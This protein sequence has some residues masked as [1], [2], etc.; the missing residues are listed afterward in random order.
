MKKSWKD[1]ESERLRNNYNYGLI[2]FMSSVLLILSFLISTGVVVGAAKGEGNKQVI[3]LV[4]DGLT[5]EEWEYARK[6]VPAIDKFVKKSSL[7]LMNTGTAGRLSSENACVTIGA[8]ARALGTGMAGLALSKD[9]IIDQYTAGVIYRRYTGKYPQGQVVHLG[10]NSLVEVNDSHHYRVEPGALGT[11][12][13]G[14]GMKTALLG[15]GDG[16][17]FNRLASTLIMDNHGMIDYG[18]VGQEI[19]KEGEDYPF[20]VSID[21]DKMWEGFLELVDKSQVIVI[22]WGDM[23]RLREKVPLLSPEKIRVN[24]DLQIENLGLFLERIM[25]LLGEERALLLFTPHPQGII[26]PSGDQISFLAMNKGPETPPVFLSSGTTQRPGLIASIDIA[27]SILDLLGLSY[28]SYL[29]GS[30]LFKIESG[31]ENNLSSLLDLKGQIN[32]IHQQRPAMIK[33]YIFSQIALVLLAV[34]ALFL[35]I[36][37]YRCIRL[38]MVFLMLA[39]LSFLIYGA[40]K[41]GNLF[42]AFLAVILLTILLTAVTSYGATNTD[43][44]L[45]VG[46]MVSLALIGDVL[47]GANLMKNSI[48]GYDPISGARFYGIGN[49]YMGVL[50]GASVLFSASLYQKKNGDKRLMSLLIPFFFAFITYLFISPAWGANFGGSLTALVAFTV[51]YLGL[52]GKN[53]RGRGIW[54]GI[55]AVALLFILSLVLLN[56]KG[57]GGMVSH[58]GRAMWL[59]RWEGVEEIYNII[60]RKLAMNIKLFQYSLWSRILVLFLVLNGLL[61]FYPPGLIRRVMLRYGRLFQGFAGIIAGSITAIIFNDSGVVAGATV[62]MYGVISLLLIA[63]EEKS[64]S[65]EY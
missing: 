13:R 35:K 39:P 63:L 49:E 18:I 28:P 21:V 14:T 22:D 43:L 61:F 4:V 64:R 33:A 19:L 9:E 55:A 60:S 20:G 23:T 1:W 41:P 34:G 8:G 54:S 17:D 3:V 27:P 6:R 31:S 48:M 5:L 50:I 26:N 11:L 45:R 57:E 47:T 7:A 38:P 51:T 15:N 46:G 10:I 12:I 29:Y 24:F 65:L 2:L 58:V 56:L 59:I 16:K 62:L 53:I 40:F 37:L 25:P 32:T 42:L 36:D 52:E 30:P 44:F